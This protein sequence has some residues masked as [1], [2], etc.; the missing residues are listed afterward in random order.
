MHR[1]LADHENLDGRHVP[2]RYPA[3][4]SAVSTPRHY[5]KV[6][7]SIPTGSFQVSGGK[8]VAAC[9]YPDGRLVDSETIPRD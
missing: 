6:C 7:S 1:L 9:D 2:W 4:L 8:E 3:T 5:D